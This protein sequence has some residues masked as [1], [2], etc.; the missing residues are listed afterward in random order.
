MLSKG[1]THSDCAVLKKAF[2]EKKVGSAE[3]A[4]E[5]SDDISHGF[6]LMSSAASLSYKSCTL[7]Y[8]PTPLCLT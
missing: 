7:A 2:E 8:T 3:I 4:Q 6:A 5:K 1:H